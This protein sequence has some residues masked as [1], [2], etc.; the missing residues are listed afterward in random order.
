MEGKGGERKQTPICNEWD[1]FFM[2]LTERKAHFSLVFT[3]SG[4]FFMQ[5]Y[6]TD[7]KESLR[8]GESLSHPLERPSWSS[9]QWKSVESNIATLQD[10][11]AK[12]TLEG[13][14]RKVRD[15]QRLLVRS[16]SARLKAV[17]QV[18]QENA[19]KG[20]SGIDG[21]LWTSPER[22]YQASLQLLRRS[23]VLPLARVYIPKKDGSQRPLGIPAMKDRANQALWAMALNP[24]VE[25]LS[26]PVSY[27]FR[28][29]R[30]CWDAHA[31]I[32]VL[33]S[34]K[35]SPQ[36]I[37]DADIQKCFDSISHEWLLENTPM[38]K[39]VLRS[40]L[41]SGFLE[42]GELFPTEAGTPQGGV[43]S[44]TLSNHALN[45]LQNLLLQRF[46]HRVQ[47]GKGTE[48]KGYTSGVNLVR[49]ADDFIVT[50]SSPR[51]LKRVQSV[52]EEF[53]RPRGLRLHPEKTKIRHITDG[54][55]FLGLTFRKASNGY[56]LRKISNDSLRSH[57]ETLRERVKRNSGI[58]P[59]ALISK[60]NPII[61][62]W[63]N[64]HRCCSNVWSA[65]HHANQY[66]FR[67]LFKWCRNKH[68][69]KS[70][71]WIYDKYW[72][73]VDGRKT[74]VA[75][76]GSDPTHYKLVPYTFRGKR[77]HRIPGSLN[78]YLLSKEVREKIRSV[79]FQNKIDGETGFRRSLWQR[80][81]GICPHCYQVLEQSGSGLTDIHH[82]VP[83][84]KGGT[85]HLSNLELL[86]EHCHYE[87]HSRGV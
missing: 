14:G 38:E 15:L 29:Y 37:L 66:L 49:Y 17:R 20:T 23:K 39:G 81:G 26:D 27:G 44:P 22:K 67:Q 48:R 24:V 70:K 60:L 78:V 56:L 72:K 5:I 71:F 74:F 2:N 52:I 41:R 79:W 28:P 35:N 73:M 43:I 57:L 7:P 32:R 42:G 82:R 21:E 83:R 69:H 4:V 16:Q 46:P 9:T 25:S 55:D 65:W 58:P 3:Q 12:A 45:G 64:Y 18:A 53:L 19:G 84:S 62:G 86:H 1:R 6:Y 8:D 34:R 68:P 54:F 40:W 36:W 75:S 77:I 11:I 85:D 76:D 80:Q 50:G 30:G 59:E 51:Q 33:L 31:Q 47:K 10:R 13:N 87:R 61:R 63:C